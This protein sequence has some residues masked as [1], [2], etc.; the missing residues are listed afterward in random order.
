[1]EQQ[2]SNGWDSDQDQLSVGPDLGSN[3]GFK[4]MFEFVCM[5]C[6]TDL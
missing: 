4:L 6:K 2:V 5:Y 3:S 1:M